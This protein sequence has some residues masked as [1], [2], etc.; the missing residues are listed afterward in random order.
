M[1]GGGNGTDGRMQADVG[2]RTDV[3]W[4]NEIYEGYREQPTEAR[5]RAVGAVGSR[6]GHQQL[7]SAVVD[8]REI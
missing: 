2:S 3:R 1:W 5:A 4:T 7:L 8:K 6:R